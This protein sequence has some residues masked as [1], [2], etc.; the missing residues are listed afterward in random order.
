MFN[1]LFMDLPVKL[2]ASMHIYFLN[3]SECIMHV[4]VAGG[5]YK[6]KFTD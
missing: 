5:L 1:P 2:T 3:Q 6:A 4:C